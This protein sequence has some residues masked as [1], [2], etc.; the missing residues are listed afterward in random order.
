M[1]VDLKHGYTPEKF[2]VLGQKLD[3]QLI[4]PINT[5]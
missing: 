1:Y 3:P 5:G 2:G 4:Q